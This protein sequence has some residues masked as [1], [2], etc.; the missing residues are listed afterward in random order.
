MFGWLFKKKTDREK[1]DLQ[2]KKLKVKAYE[3]SKTDRKASD[4][5]NAEAE[6]VSKM[7]EE[8]DMIE[9]KARNEAGN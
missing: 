9:A 5:L 4:A 7:I 6:G 1:L 3:L 2:Y 8:L